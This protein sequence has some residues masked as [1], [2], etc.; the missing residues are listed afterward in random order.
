M[1]TLLSA[2]LLFV[3][4]CSNDLSV[5]S[6][7]PNSGTY[8]GGEEVTIHGRGFQPGRSGVIVKFG[9]HQAASVSVEST[10]S[11]KVQTP[12][13]DKNAGVD[14]MIVF[15]DGKAYVL[16]NGFRYV[17]T[18]QKPTVGQALDSVGKKP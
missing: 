15:D 1:R 5:S 6:I 8:M 18:S 14:V 17:D 11:I 2:A 12:A 4:A 13:G 7:E 10:G 3:G 9:T 16:K